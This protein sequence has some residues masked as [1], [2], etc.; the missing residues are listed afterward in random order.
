MD[1]HDVSYERACMEIQSKNSNSA[2][3]DSKVQVDAKSDSKELIDRIS[4]SEEL[5]NAVS[6]AVVYRYY[7]FNNK[8]ETMD[9]F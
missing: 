4:D 1:R 2:Q 3:S 5:V 8:F 9:I 7:I 6:K